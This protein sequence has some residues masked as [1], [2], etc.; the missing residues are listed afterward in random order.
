MK[1]VNGIYLWFDAT[2][3]IPAEDTVPFPVMLAKWIMNTSSLLFNDL[4]SFSKP[5]YKKLLLS[6]IN[7]NDRW[8]VV[9][10]YSNPIVVVMKL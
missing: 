6:S 3:M 8:I 2:A 4:V 7:W 9:G 5:A 10:E 1:L